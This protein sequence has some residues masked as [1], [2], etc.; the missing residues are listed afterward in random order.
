MMIIINPAEIHLYLYKTSPCRIMLNLIEDLPVEL[1]G[2]NVLVFLSL[3]DIVLLERACGSKKSHQ[4]FCCIIPYCPP[5][6]FP[7]SLKWNMPSV[8]WSL[9]R[10][11][12]I[13]TLSIRVPVDNHVK[14][15]HVNNFHLYVFSN[16]TIEH[17]KCLNENIILSYVTMIVVNGNIDKEV[18]DQLISCTGNVKQLTIRN[19]DNCMDWL[20]VDILTKWKLKEI[21]IKGTTITAQFFILISELTCIKL[22]SYNINDD[23]VIYIA[24]NSPHLERLQFSSEN[25]TEVSIF[26]LSKMCLF[27]KELDIRFIPKFSTPGFAYYCSHALSC[28]RHLSTDQID[29]NKQD[30][31]ILIP[32]MTGI[33]SLDLG[34]S[35]YSNVQ[36]LTQYCH[37]LTRIYVYG[38]NYHVTDILSLFCANPLLEEIACYYP[39]KITDTA[40]IELIHACPH[41][42]SIFLP[43]VTTISDISILA[44]SE[45]CTQLQQLVCE[46]CKDITETA[47]VELVQRCRK[48]TDFR[49]HSNSLSE[50][51]RKELKKTRNHLLIQIN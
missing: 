3:K 41:L 37:K 35:F 21:D 5:I 45:H 4:H 30:A 11:C 8:Y 29:R 14:G 16:T 33:T 23:I 25:I 17:I 22:N 19:S 7:S 38:D 24:Q 47:V 48:L 6:E 50:E 39:C 44:L 32:Y 43:Y 1:V 34:Y 15:L 51:T 2:T 42:H 18:M 36:L 31:T 40:L 26:S 46:E 12:K 13:E 9:K 10:R 49:V 20:T 27:L 28:I